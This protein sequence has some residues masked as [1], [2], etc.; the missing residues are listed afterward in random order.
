VFKRSFD[1]GASLVGIAEDSFADMAGYEFL[2]LWSC[3]K[4]LASGADWW[5]VPYLFA[6]EVTRTIAFASGQRAHLLPRSIKRKLSLHKY[7]WEGKRALV[8]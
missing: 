1:S 2:H 4:E 7:Y 5:R 3:T 8:P 6:Y